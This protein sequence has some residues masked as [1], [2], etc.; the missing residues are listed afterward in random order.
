M[1][2]SR[3][4]DETGQVFQVDLGR[5]D[6]EVM[7][8]GMKAFVIPLDGTGIGTYWGG[9]NDGKPSGKLFWDA[10]LLIDSTKREAVSQGTIEFG[11]I[12]YEF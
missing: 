1:L 12:A 7:R 11:P 8:K 9:S 10:L 5:L 2:R 3:F 6:E 4:R